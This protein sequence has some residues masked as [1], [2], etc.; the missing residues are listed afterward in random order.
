METQ[1]RTNF[2]NRTMESKFNMRRIFCLNG[3]ELKI[4]K[5]MDS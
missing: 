3:A 4:G 1:L 2:K 5:W